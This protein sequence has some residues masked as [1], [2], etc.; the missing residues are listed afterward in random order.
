MGGT[1]TGGQ[2]F[3]GFDPFD[4]KEQP[5]GPPRQWFTGALRDVAIRGYVLDKER[6]KNGAFLSKEYDDNLLA[7]MPEFSFPSRS[8]LPRGPAIC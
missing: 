5:R 7:E 8:A 1:Q 2:L 4:L 3:G 6:R